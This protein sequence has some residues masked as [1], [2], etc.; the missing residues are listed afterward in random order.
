MMMM[1]MMILLLLL[2][3]QWLIEDSQTE[4]VCRQWNKYMQWASERWWQRKNSKQAAGNI[5]CLTLEECVSWYLAAGCWPAFSAALSCLGTTAVR[6]CIVPSG[7]CLRS[8]CF[9]LLMTSRRHILSEQVGFQWTGLCSHFSN[10]SSSDAWSQSSVT[11][12]LHLKTW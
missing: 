10:H 6:Q 4:C 5:V 2:L 1:M 8:H 3:L 9:P 12:K 7:L 11:G